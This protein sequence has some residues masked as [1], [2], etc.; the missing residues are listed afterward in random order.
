MVDLGPSNDITEWILKIDGDP[1]SPFKGRRFILKMDFK[2]DYPFMPPKINYV[3]KIF[4]PGVDQINGEINMGPV[5]RAPW[6]PLRGIRFCIQFLISQMRAVN[7][8]NALADFSNVQGRQ[9]PNTIC[10]C[11]TKIGEIF[12]NQYRDYIDLAKIATEAE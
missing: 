2:D 7:N 3:T 11:A 4:H 10:E 1:D 9:D 6:H 5:E 8:E 12:R